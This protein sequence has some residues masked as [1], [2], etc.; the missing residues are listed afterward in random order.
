MVANAKD[1]EPSRVSFSNQ[2]LG[3]TAPAILV[4]RGPRALDAAAAALPR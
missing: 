3:Q 1:R 4:N 2:A